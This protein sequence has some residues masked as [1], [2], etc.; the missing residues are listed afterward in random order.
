MDQELKSLVMGANF[1]EYMRT[2]S[3]KD[4]ENIPGAT[5]LNMTDNGTTMKE[6]EKELLNRRI[7]KYI[8]VNGLII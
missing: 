2:I 1:K 3:N 8:T 5:N 7:K 4:G 6:M